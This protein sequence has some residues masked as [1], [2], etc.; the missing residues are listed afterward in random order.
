MTL[1]IYLYIFSHTV[2]LDINTLNVIIIY[3]LFMILHDE[4][5]K[6]MTIPVTVLEIEVLFA[7]LGTIYLWFGNDK[8]NY[9]DIISGVIST[10]FWF[11][12]AMS[13]LIGIYSDTVQ[14]VSTALFFVF[15]AIGII[16]AL[17]TI[18]KIIDSMQAKK[19]HIGSMEIDLKI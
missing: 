9:T 6:I 2:S 5:D 16:V 12:T 13:F 7:L 11:L 18:V 8:F 19:D 14:F 10:I 15:L 17:I 3:K 1:H 4:D